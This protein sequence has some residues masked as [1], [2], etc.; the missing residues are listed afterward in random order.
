M[1]GHIGTLHPS[2]IRCAELQ[3]HNQV[4]EALDL[5][6]AI[7]GQLA[8]TNLQPIGFFHNERIDRNSGGAQPSEVDQRTLRSGRNGDGIGGEV[9]DVDLTCGG[10]GRRSLA[11]GIAEQNRACEGELR[12]VG[13]DQGLRIA[14]QASHRGR[15]RCRRIHLCDTRSHC[16]EQRVGGC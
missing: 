7:G 13:G 10:E 6:D 9:G 16:I 3:I 5:V 1:R 4:V 8:P 11:E 15:H 14:A 12:G 2:Q